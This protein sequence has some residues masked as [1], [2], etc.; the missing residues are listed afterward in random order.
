M[1]KS[2]PLLL[3]IDIGTNG[4]KAA[5]VHPSGAISAKAFIEHCVH[6]PRPDWCEADMLQDWWFDT[7]AVIRQVIDSTGITPDQIRCVATSGLYPAFGPTDAEGNPLCGAILYSD[8]R[9]V[10]EVAE[11][12]QRFN[13]RLSSEELTPKL[14]WFLRHA[15]DLAARMR[16]FFDAAHFAVYKLC[17]AYVVD[18]ITCGLFG[19]IYESPTAS[20]RTEVC[21]ELDIPSEVLP[22]VYPPA[23]VVGN[24]HAEA[25]RLTGL[26]P[27]TPVIC[28]MP[29][30]YASMISAG[31]VHRWESIAYYGSAGVLPV[32]KDEALNAARK[33]FPIPERGG[34][35]QEG[36]LYDYPVYSLSVG[37][38]VYWFRENFGQPECE[39]AR[40]E[41]GLSA[42]ARLDRLAEQIPPGSEGVILL[43]YFQGQRS[44]KFDPN[45]S[46]CYFG[47]KSTY[48]RGH[49]YRA[50]LESWGYAIR[51]GLESMYP[52]GHPLKRL[53][54]TGGGARSPLWR[55]IVSDITG[56][57]QDYVAEAEGP[58]GAAYLAGL[59]I[60]IFTDFSALKRDWVKVTE[61][62]W[63][64]LQTKEIYDRFF[65]LYVE[66]HDALRPL[67]THSAEIQMTFGV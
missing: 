60:G 28:G 61:T 53:V 37:H 49:L 22:E 44:P 55:Q 6:H 66:L 10:A 7:V 41:G 39:L 3:G 35:V 65:P 25:A 64:D 30:L 54:A 29:D 11:I 63:P 18:T 34:K 23:Q 45:A 56:I 48:G 24:V 5:L 67:Y 15:P 52:Q 43:P 1:N 17:G 19:A 13:L 2:E 14:V 42:Y 58:V 26:A 62:T 12:N 47:L 59:G 57:P 4:V 38:G 27:G 8:N 33:P 50:L 9:S 36:Y 40:Q 31:A 46:A 32:M 51:H 21:A 20:W 16:M